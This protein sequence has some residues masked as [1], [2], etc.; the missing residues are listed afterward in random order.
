[1]LGDTIEDAAEHAVQLGPLGNILR[2]AP[3]DVQARVADEMREAMTP[4][5]QS[6]GVRLGA[7]CWL[8]TAV[9]P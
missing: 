3:D 4:H 8:A 1:L 7:S 6:D 5:L 9:A 2:E